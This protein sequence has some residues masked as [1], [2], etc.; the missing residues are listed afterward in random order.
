MSA[1]HYHYLKTAPAGSKPARFA[2]LGVALV[3]AGRTRDDPVAETLELAAWAATIIHGGTV[4]WYDHNCTKGNRPTGVLDWLRRKLR[5]GECLDCWTINALPVMHAIGLWR[6]IEDGKWHLKDGTWTGAAV[7]SDPPVIVTLRPAKCHGVLRLLDLRNLGVRTVDDLRAAADA[8][9]TCSQDWP[10]NGWDATECAVAIDEAI[11]EYLC[12][13]YDMLDTEELGAPKPTLA[14]QAWGAYRA[15]FMDAPILCHANYPA[16]Q[17]EESAVFQGRT[18]AFRLGRIEGPVYHLD[19]QSHYASLCLGETF[20][21]R[22]KHYR[23]EGNHD[24]TRWMRDGWLI[25]AEVE[26][27][28]GRNIYPCDY[29]GLQIFPHGDF[30]TTLCCGELVEALV[31]DHVRKVCRFAAYEPEEMLDGWA[32]WCLAQRAECRAR[33]DRVGEYVVKMLTNG[34]W[35]RWAK[36]DL[37][38]RN[39]PDLES[40]NNAKWSEWYDYCGEN[41]EHFR[42]IGGLVQQFCDDGY[43]KDACPAV[44]AWLTSLGRYDLWE[45][46]QAAHPGNIYYC[47]TDSLMVDE[48][49]YF[50]LGY[51][52]FL[53]DGKPGK[54]KLVNKYKWIHIYGIHHYETDIGA[55]SAGIPAAHN[56]NESDGF[57]WDSTEKVTGALRRHEMPRALIVPKAR[58]AAGPYRHGRLMANGRIS[59]IILPET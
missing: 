12:R 35:G 10:S 25:I 5:K 57:S 55:T 44:Y 18:E 19:Y 29:N 21:A 47:A 38:W 39:E 3:S 36:R 8:P 46:M 56:G 52:G 14:G 31:N 42:S 34:M 17:L 45:T 22:L 6:A 43:G 9:H 1:R 11:G 13:W 7:L 4:E 37:R 33:D 24:L 28:T 41:L 23:A 51:M 32:Q 2:T 15:R 26:L 59:P 27:S 54:L 49:S 20:P 50:N 58:K 40:Q 30:R 16:L 53:G 48:D